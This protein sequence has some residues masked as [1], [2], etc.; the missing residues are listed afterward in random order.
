[1]EQNSSSTFMRVSNEISSRKSHCYH[2]N[3]IEAVRRRPRLLAETKRLAEIQVA[4]AIEPK[5]CAVCF[6]AHNEPIHDATVRI[7]TWHKSAVLRYLEN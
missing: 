7:R 1:M 5:E 3:A 4:A 2:V 6:G